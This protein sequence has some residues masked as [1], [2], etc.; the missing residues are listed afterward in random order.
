MRKM[1]WDAMNVGLINNMK[2][3]MKE[4]TLCSFP[5][6]QM[7]SEL[8]QASERDINAEVILNLRIMSRKFR[9]GRPF[10]VAIRTL[11]VST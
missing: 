3:S 5:E 10:Q 4:P 11:S 7:D 1:S 9:V 6:V 8:E 2:L